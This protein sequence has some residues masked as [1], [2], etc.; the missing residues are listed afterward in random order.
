MKRIVFLG[1]ENS[2]SAMFINF[3][4][5]DEKY[6]DIEILGVYSHD[7]NAAKNLPSTTPP[8]DTGEVKSN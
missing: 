1:C 6:N 5:G 3:I 8:S 4:K 2:H 7:E